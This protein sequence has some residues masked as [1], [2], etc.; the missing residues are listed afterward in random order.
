MEWIFGVK[1]EGRCWQ[2]KVL[3]CRQKPLWLITCLQQPL[4]VLNFCHG[5]YY[6]CPISWDFSLL[7]SWL[8]VFIFI[9][10]Y[11]IEHMHFASYCSAW[12]G[13]WTRRP[14]EVP[15]RLSCSVALCALMLYGSVLFQGLKDFCIELVHN[16]F[17]FD[18]FHLGTFASV[19]L[20]FLLNSQL[21]FFFLC[22]Q[23][24]CEIKI[25]IVTPAYT[26]FMSPL[27]QSHSSPNIL[28][29][30]NFPNTTN[31]QTDKK[32]PIPIQW[33]SLNHPSA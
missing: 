7:I 8:M 29:F 12:H 27:A 9:L 18:C 11:F 26:I 6:A 14:S 2:S 31:K 22:I 17:C 21:C 13:G 30:F 28:L 4:M 32:K 20:Y 1:S 25:C 23:Y 33:N 3:L 16:S 24:H 15:S 10:F 19:T 5:I